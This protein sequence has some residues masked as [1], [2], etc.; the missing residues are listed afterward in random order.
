MTT[1]LFL[2]GGAIALLSAVMIYNLLIRRRNRVDNAFAGVDAYLTMRYELI[3]NLVR[4]V[5]AYASHESQVFAQITD[6]RAQALQGDLGSDQ[7]VRLA[8]RIEPCMQGLFALAEGYPALRADAGFQQL[9]RS[10]NE[11]EERIS[12]ARRAFNASVLDYNNAVEAFPSNLVA[13]AM[14]FQRRAFFESADTAR[15][16]P[17]VSGG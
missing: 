2:S 7:R 8:N 12:A 4:T 5:Q 10:L 3:P 14:Q 15:Q 11:I 6:L 9:Q 16:H 13:G 1:T 17:G